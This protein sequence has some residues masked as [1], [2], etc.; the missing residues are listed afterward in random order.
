MKESNK[1]IVWLFIGAVSLMLAVSL[2]LLTVK[3]KRVRADGCEHNTGTY[4]CSCSVRGVTQIHCNSCHE[5]LETTE[6]IE[7]TESV[8]SPENM[9]QE[10]KATCAKDGCIFADCTIC[11][12][13]VIYEYIPATNQHTLIP[14]PDSCSLRC[15]V[16]DDLFD[17][18]D[19]DSPYHKPDKEATCTEGSKCIY[20]GLELH[21][22]LE[23]NPITI[24][25][26]ENRYC[27]RCYISMEVYSHTMNNGTCVVCG[28]SE[29]QPHSIE[30]EVTT[31]NL[32]IYLKKVL[33]YIL[34]WFRV[35]WG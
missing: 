7:F 19:V 10:F 17:N 14:E 22:P 3:V 16:C 29:I 26:T 12:L 23:H 24:N 5:I 9:T 30:E 13:P 1:G 11:G 31:S 2:I 27:G 18:Y 33:F 34:K 8:H 28:Y 4:E 20:C 6:G 21:S 32:F 35:F 25:C 15:E